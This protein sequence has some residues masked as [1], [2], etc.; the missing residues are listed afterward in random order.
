[1]RQSGGERLRASPPGLGEAEHE[2]WIA[3]AV[4][5]AVEAGEA[6]G[7]EPRGGRHRHKGERI[8]A[9]PPVVSARRDGAAAAEE[10]P[11]QEIERPGGELGDC[12]AMAKRKARSHVRSAEAIR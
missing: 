8:A 5:G 1:M 6:L 10:A 4:A 9:A 7:D 11:A 3:A 2:R 12:G